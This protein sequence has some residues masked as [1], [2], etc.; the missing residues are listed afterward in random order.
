MKK[1]MLSGVLMVLIVSMGLVGCGYDGN[2]ET[3]STV[4]PEEYEATE[5]DG[6]FEVTI[7]V[8]GKDNDLSVAASITYLGDEDT[9][10]IYHGGSIFYFNIYQQDGDFQ[11][12]GAMDAQLHSTKLVQNEPHRVEIHY[13]ILEELEPGTYEFEAEAVFSLDEENI[14]DSTINLPVSV[15][16]TTD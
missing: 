9:I 11:Y 7:E 10:D 4:E 2:N 15:I 12:L 5:R 14:A 3:D 13:P 1:L 16:I 8:D 6:D